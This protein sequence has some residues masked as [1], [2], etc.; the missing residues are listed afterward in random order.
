M[1]LCGSCGVEVGK[2]CFHRPLQESVEI[3]QEELINVPQT[4]PNDKELNGPSAKDFAEMKKWDEIEQRFLNGWMNR[5]FTR[6]MENHLQ[7]T[8]KQEQLL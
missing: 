5:E 7:D 3:Y 4:S 6:W 2:G 1:A 8:S